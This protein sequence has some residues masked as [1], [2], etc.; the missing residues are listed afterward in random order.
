MRILV[1]GRSGQ[2]AR[3]IKD[4]Y[5]GAMLCGRPDLDLQR[6]ETIAAAIAAMKPDVVVN[7][8]AYTAVD[9]AESDADAA[10]AINRDGAAAAAQAAAGHDLPIIQISTDYVYSGSKEGAYVETDTA[11]PASI[12]GASKLAGEEAVRAANPMHVILRTAWVYSPYGKN[13][14]KTMLD[15]AKSR[16][17]LRVVDDQRGNPTSAADLADAVICVARRMMQDPDFGGLFHY[18]GRGDVSWCG[19]ARQIFTISESLGGP[20]ARVEA[21][22]TAE[23]PTPARRPQ[24]SRLDCSAYERVFGRTIPAWQDSLRDCVTR[25]LHG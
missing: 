17:V 5:P 20:Q 21:I 14:V 3:S 7:A 2:L 1:T 25:L 15:L 18:A 12:Y 24:N 8:A 9:A 19:F 10:F 16:P 11:G 4:R 23:Y 22:A 13:F 6:P